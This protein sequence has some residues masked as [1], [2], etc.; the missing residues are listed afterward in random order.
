MA[1][2]RARA[3]KPVEVVE[4]EE[5]EIMEQDQEEQEE[6]EAAPEEG[7]Q[8][9]END[10]EEVELR[11]LNFDQELSWRPAKPIPTATLIKRLEA[12][13][14]EL[15][16]L[17]QGATDLDSLKKVAKHLGHR[18]LIQ[19]KDQGVRAYTACCLVD[20][21]R[22]FV[23]DA[24]YSDDQ[25]QSMFSLFINVILPALHNPTNPYDSQHKYVLTSLTD[26]K[27]ILLL[28]DISG[29]DGLM[30]QLFKTTFDGVS[31]SGSKPATE[32]QV[33]KDVE[34]HLTEMLMQLID[35]SASVSADV[36]DAIISQFLRAG[37]S[38]DKRSREQNGNQ[39]T[40]LIKTEPPAYVMA[41]NIC[42]GCSD[43][44]ARYVSQ[45]FSD[46][47]LNASSFATKSNGHRQGDDDDEDAAQGPSSSELKSLDQ[48][49]NLI[50]ELW[51]AAPAV[52]VSVVPQ[53]EAEL[54]ADNVYLRQIATETIGD[55]I[56]GI[57][58]AGPPPA[59]VLEPAAYP[60]LKLLD[61]RP[62]PA[63]ENVL[64]KP[65]S[66]HSFA[67]THHTA[68]RNFVGRR[69]D[70]TGTIR[71]AWVTAAGYI[72]ATSAGGIGL[73][74]ED[75]LE[76]VKALSDKLNDSE[77]KVRLAAVKAIELFDFRDIILKLG[78]IGGVEKAGSIFA[79]LAD[80]CRDRRPAVRV[81]AMV[82]LGKLWAVG[83]GEIADG[84]DAVTTCLSG[85]PSRIINAFYA[86]DPDL[87]VL[88]DRVMFECLIPL[89][90]P[91]IKGG[92]AAKAS[93]QSQSQTGGSQADQ[94]KIRAERILLML[95]FLDA[96]AKKA[97]FAMQARQPQVAKGVEVFIQQCEAHNGG[98]GHANEEKV[99]KVLE[100]TYQWFGTFLPDPLKVRSDLQKFA[101][102]NDRRCYQLVKWT[103][104]SDSDFLTVRRSMNE[105][106]GRIQASPSAAGCLDTLIPLLYR[107][108][109]LMYNRSHL[110]TIM[111]YSKND[112]GGFAAVAHEVLNDIS[113]RNPDL[114]KA[115]SETLRKE[116]IDQVPSETRSNDPGMVDILKAYSSFSKRYPKD[117]TYDRKFIQVLMDYALYGTPART[118]KYAV[119]I[120][121]A[122]NDDKSK[123]T[124]TNLMQKVMKDLDYG[125]PHFLNKLTAVSQLERLAPTVT[126]DFDDAINE[127][128]IQKILRQVRTEDENPEVSWVED[129]DMNEEL[130]A[131]ILSLRTLVNQALATQEDPDTE[132]VKTVFKLLKDLLVNEG[133]FCKVKD[134][135]LAHKKRLRLL[136]GLLV[137]KMC[138]VKRYDEL[139]DHAS[140][141]KLAELIQDTE[142]QVRRFFMEKL[143]NYLSRG[144]LPGRFY[145]I[146][147]LAAF[148]PAAEL[149][150]RVETWLRS[151]A[152]SLAEAKRRVLES[153]MSRLIPLLAHH[154]DYSSDVNDLAD[155]ANYFLFYLN[156][157]ATEENISLIY[158]YAE[159]VKQ[160]RDAITPEASERLYVLSDLAT[161]VTR[162]WQEKK[163]WVFQAY[164]AKVGMPQ[165]LVQALTS[166]E[167][168]RE[169]AKKQYIP[170][171]L[172]EKLDDLIRALDRKK[173]RKS[174]SERQDPPAKR[175]RTQSK[176]ASREKKPKTPKAKKVS[177]SRKPRP[178]RDSPPPSERR[179]SGRA[180]KVS[181]YTERDDDEDEAEMLE[182]VASWQ[183]EGD[184]DGSGDDNE[185]GSDA[186]SELSDAPSEEQAEESGAESDKEELEKED[187][188]DNET[189]EMEVDEPEPPKSNGRK[190][191]ALASRTKAAAKSAVKASVLTEAKRPTRSTRSRR[192][193]E[194][195]EMDVDDD[196]E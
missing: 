115:H 111:D 79:S 144:R 126:V 148:E 74:R 145:A 187:D 192:G 66:P 180:H 4:E 112:K 89:K 27:S 86:N 5:E 122:R 61:E 179:R 136:A 36:V 170:D 109:S 12:L 85:V 90:Y 23:P 185:A 43:K 169:I 24:P 118:A 63:V 38:K 3:Q 91:I 70:K 32:E 161:A 33:A 141:N 146:L 22:L 60:P 121:L 2:R 17:D 78:V 102:F 168:A 162:K 62:A 133:E 77:E 151:R 152:R 8:A 157:C 65:Y 107:S 147:F 196:E 130:Q 72:L 149:K 98:V 99:Q 129:A 190:T 19:H 155:F 178:S 93:S 59:P 94:D 164:P 96:P 95:K 140:F 173:K 21:L 127:L 105:M 52:L 49:H 101:K 163:N 40:L 110:A 20:I 175:V 58:V 97:F 154:P 57:G 44:M 171:E 137:L 37:P 114:F 82:L 125:S 42:N 56:S 50:R 54:S 55:M 47:I 120:L 71:A 194:S 132:R 41:K 139:F 124:A 13:S 176:T 34:I 69:N 81:D 45:Y 191:A 165:G 53:I 160:T 31:K 134:T 174:M 106:F 75:E 195:A 103:I 172:D 11:S 177:K 153:I 108:G 92:K 46:V 18:N 159:R 39:S 150:S 119:N 9:S 30:K 186:E 189:P 158:K 182:G 142:L 64:T 25:L 113:Q 156:T 10:D 193:K 104:S 68:Y 7:D 166:N 48:A 181:V 84:Q 167:E 135:P 6:Q 183:Y 29:G 88:L 138:T 26:V 188:D 16:E 128:T 14:K 73:S 100:K 131:K 15:S 117:I 123:V 1:R 184:S 28:Q 116:I 80:R 87:N 35:E 83:S 76:L 51:R 143:Q 67:Q